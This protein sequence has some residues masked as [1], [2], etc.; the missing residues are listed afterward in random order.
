MLRQP[1]EIEEVEFPN[2]RAS[3]GVDEACDLALCE[4]AVFGPPSELMLS[5]GSRWGSIWRESSFENVTAA[6]GRTEANAR[7]SLRH[8]G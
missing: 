8:E 7:T 3:M 1:G 2:H 5:A 4:V 6:G